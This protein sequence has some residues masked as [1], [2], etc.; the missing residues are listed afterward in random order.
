M[1]GL[2][3][4]DQVGP[5]RIVRKIA[6]GGMATVFE[7]DVPATGER[8][9]LKVPH[10]SFRQDRD[11]LRRFMRESRA[12]M[13][14]RSPHVVRILSVG[15]LQNNMPYLAMEYIDGLTLRDL[16]YGPQAQALS[17]DSVLTLIDQVASAIEAAHRVGVIHR[18]IKPDN[19]LIVFGHE[20]PV[21]KVFDFGLSLLAVEFSISRLT[22]TGVTFGTPQYMPPEQIRSARD[23]D[24]RSDIYSLG[25]I[26]YEML[27]GRWPFEG[28][29]LQEV[30]ISTTR[31]RPVSLSTWRPDLPSGLVDE[32]MK[33]ISRDPNQRQA[34]ATAFRAALAPFLTE[35]ATSDAARPAPQAPQAEPALASAPP[36]TRL[37]GRLRHEWVLAAAGLALLVLATLLV[38]VVRIWIW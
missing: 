29:S 17:L 27:A 20:R 7:A 37:R 6:I 34:S 16:M 11:V 25:V 18:D 26:M 5:Y 13:A 8:V 19:V 24:E 22:T 30:W 1:N 38:V 31:T 35:S 21:A 3:P 33:A 36:R 28:T 23:A 2:Q 4:G 32:I 10:D 14:I 15:K 9:A 12:A